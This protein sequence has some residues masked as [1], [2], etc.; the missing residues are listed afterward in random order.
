MKANIEGILNRK[1]DIALSIIAENIYKLYDDGIDILLIMDLLLEVPLPKRYIESIKDI[2]NL[3]TNGESLGNSLKHHKNIYP[4]FFISMVEVGEKSGKLSN[5]LKCLEAYYKKIGLIKKTIINALSYPFIVI[6]SMLVLAIFLVL[7]VIPSF[8]DIYLSS[9]MEVPTSCLVMY[10]FAEFFKDNRL[11][12]SL[13]IISW[14][15]VLPIILFRILY[16][17]YIENFLNKIHIVNT[18]NEYIFIS[19]LSIIT[20]SGINLSKG[21]D[22][23]A[24]SFKGKNVKNSFVIINDKILEG[25]SL[26]ESLEDINGYSKYTF[27]MIKLGE[28]SGGMDERLRS[29]SSYLEN[30]VNSNIKKWMTLIQPIAILLMAGLVLIFIIIFIIPLFDA[31]LGGVK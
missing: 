26:G 3:I 1:S 22:Y 19:L 24:R 4:E 30:K 7:F 8:Y 11:I 20:S 13:Y 16:K 18:F 6:I 17:N 14:G 2:K 15:M 27:S 9:G 29:L 10:K 21:L 28:I 23:C 25:K 12:A 5:V 31:L